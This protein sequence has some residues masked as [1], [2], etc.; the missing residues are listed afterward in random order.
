MRRVRMTD[1]PPRPRRRL[2]LDGGQTVLNR[3]Y[4]LRAE[5][6]A[7]TVAPPSHRVDHC[8][9]HEFGAQAPCPLHQ[10]YQ[11][12]PPLHIGNGL[13]RSKFTLGLS[14]CK[15]LGPLRLMRSLGTVGRISHESGNITLPRKGP[16]GPCCVDIV[17]CSCQYGN[18]GEVGSGYRSLLCS[19]SRPCRTFTPMPR[20]SS[21]SW[22]V[23]IQS[24]R[25]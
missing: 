23:W 16:T 22:W 5:P 11:F 13:Q 14:H 3:S 9:R 12:E 8:G 18:T 24:R 10:W 19:I 4:D 2:A 17:S 20:L 15:C 6:G 1:S 25:T 21:S 7:M